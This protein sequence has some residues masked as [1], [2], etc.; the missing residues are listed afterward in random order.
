MQINILQDDDIEDIVGDVKRTDSQKSVATSN[1]YTMEFTD[2]SSERYNSS[3]KGT[4]VIDHD[5]SEDSDIN[6][7]LRRIKSTVNLKDKEEKK[8]LVPIKSNLDKNTQFEIT[9]T[10]SR[11]AS[12]SSNRCSIFAQETFTQ[13]SK[14]IIELASLDIERKVD[15]KTLETQTSLVSI[16]E[17]RTMEYRI[18]IN[19]QNKYE[20]TNSADDKNAIDLAISLNQAFNSSLDDGSSKF[21]VSETEN[22]GDDADA[23]Y[24]SS[25]RLINILNVDSKEIDLSE[26]QNDNQY[27]NTSDF[28]TTNTDIEEDSLMEQPKP[29]VNSES[30][31]DVSDVPKSVDNDI[32]ELYTKLSGSINEYSLENP[33]EIEKQRLSPLTTLTEESAL[34]GSSKVT[35]IVNTAIDDDVL[36]TNNE[37]MKIK[38]LPEEVVTKHQVYELPP[39]RNGSCPNSPPLNFLFSMTPTTTRPVTKSGTLPSVVEGNSENRWEITTRDLAAG[40]ST[41]I[42]GRSGK[43]SCFKGT[44]FRK[45]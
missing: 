16:T 28:E 29:K 37:G 9:T 18:E 5:T 27:E 3:G 11:A 1:V 34:I 4:Y 2:C 40:E 45:L 14:T 38:L 31:S 8:S 21:P 24:S 23:S 39:I 42:S 19:N 10:V 43:N 12:T 41:N 13:T 6:F 22:E 17:N 25:E 30:L 33:C 44:K 7:P 15:S 35:S 36:F 26:E 32:E 20:I